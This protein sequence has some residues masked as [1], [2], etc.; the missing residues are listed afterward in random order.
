MLG[1]ALPGLPGLT[2]GRTNNISWGITAA[3]T[4]ISDLYKEKIVGEKY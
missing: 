1:A 4:D 2:F 3:V